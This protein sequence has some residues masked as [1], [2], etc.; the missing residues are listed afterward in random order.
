MN[1]A[2]TFAFGSDLLL[3][4]PVR[5][6]IVEHLAGLPC[7]QDPVDSET[8]GVRRSDGAGLTAHALAEICK[9]HVTTVRFHLD[10]LVDGGVVESWSERTPGAGRPRKLY[11]L[12]QGSLQ[13][14]PD[15]EAYRMFTRLLISGVVAGDGQAAPEEAGREW[16]HH[17][18]PPHDA[19]GVNLTTP[20]PATA[21]GSWLAKVGHLVDLLSSW[22][23]GSTLSTRNDG[24]TVDLTLYDC[25][26]L[27]LAR[28]HPEV[29]CAVH[30][31]L[32]A[33]TLEK[34]GETEA[35]VDLR[36][37][38]TNRTCSA[39]ITTHANFTA[40]RRSVESTHTSRPTQ[41]GEN[42]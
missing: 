33:G 42:P 5:R 38:V 39:H 1:K 31:G 29:V 25:P 22:G 10:R 11:A 41:T 23:C 27:P 24:H 7:G 3:E 14:V 26:M 2:N 8:D 4:S 18:V 19:D 35:E 20:A 6:Q 28:E 30:R 32:L 37:C 36:P 34:L 16:A 17:H 13:T 9:L 15:A 40:S 21:P 12:P